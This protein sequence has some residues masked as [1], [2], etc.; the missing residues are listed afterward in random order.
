M[1]VQ[2]IIKHRRDTAATWLSVNPVLASGEI[3]LETDTGLKK[4]GNGTA[5]W[6]ALAYE[7]VSRVVQAVKNSTGAS[8]SKG[9]AVYIS[10]ATGDNALVSLADAD[11]E[12]TSSKTLG[13]METTVADGGFGNVIT[14]GLISGINT[15]TATAGQSVWLSSTAGQ[16]AF[17]NPPAKPAH[18]VYLGV[19]IRAHSTQGEILVK[20]QNGYELN[21]LHDV[22]AGSP[23]SGDALVWNGTKWVNQQVDVSGAI[24]TH[25]SD[26]TNVH[27]IADTSAL[28][29]T[30]GA[31]AKADQAESDANA[32]AD[33]LATNYDAAGTAD[34]AVSTHNSATTSVHG[35]ADTSLLATKSYADNAAATAAAAVV[36]AAPS[37]LDTLNELAAA[38]GDDA[39]YAATISTAL[40]TKQGKVTG[41]TDTEIGY[42][43]GVTSAIQTQIDGKSATGHTHTVSE[44]TDYTPVDISGKQD[45]VTGVTD[46]EIGYL[47]GVTSNIQDQINNAGSPIHPMFL[48]GGI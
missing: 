12:S 48:V 18:G 1:A 47:D 14:D 45:K 32:Y 26:T 38:L 11:A 43:D 34:T 40:G 9:S 10:G 16:F 3:G 30:T 27:G 5:A 23:T 37:T 24:S 46:T 7:A 39:N 29:T 25:N 44:I 28:E 2:T 42:L 19:V 31:Q 15:G 21:E 41:V 20:V 13:L 36:D 8:I 33:S 22:D 6:D 35:I 17:G 4:I